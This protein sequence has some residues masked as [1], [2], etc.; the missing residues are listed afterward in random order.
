MGIIENHSTELL[1]YSLWITLKHNHCLNRREGEGEG[2]EREG[3]GEGK[4]RE[5]EGEGKEREGRGRRE[6]RGRRR[7]GRGEV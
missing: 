7:K 5:G 1:Q 3:E 6:R 2:E 4:E